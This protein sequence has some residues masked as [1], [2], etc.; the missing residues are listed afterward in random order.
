[1]ATY[2]FTISGF[3]DSAD[4]QKAIELADKIKAAHPEKDITFEKLCLPS[5]AD[6]E[7]HRASILHKL[8]KSA[9]S[10][11]SHPLVYTSLKNKPVEFIGGYEDFLNQVAR[12]EFKMQL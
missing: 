8:N 4:Y 3:K 1:M 9:D 10:F 11:T 6:F 2:H 7:T 5:M 12:V